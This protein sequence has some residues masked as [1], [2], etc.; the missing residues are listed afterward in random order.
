VN[1]PFLCSNIPAASAYGIYLSK[2]IRYSR[3]CDSYQ[4]FLGRGKITFTFTVSIYGRSFIRFHRDCTIQQGRHGEFL[5]ADWL[6]FKKSSLKLGGT[7]VF[8]NR[9][10]RNNNCLRRPCL[11]TDRDKIINHYTKDTDRSASYL[12]LHIKIDNEGW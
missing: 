10:S 7:K 3:T 5:F 12:D 8:R 2:L 6:K 1:F 11:S 9:H 4:D